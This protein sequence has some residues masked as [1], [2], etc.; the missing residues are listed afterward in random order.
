MRSLW[1]DP[2]KTGQE[3]SPSGLC[4][5]DFC[6]LHAVPL[7]LATRTP[8]TPHPHPAGRPSDSRES[9][10]HQLCLRQEGGLPPGG[11]SLWIT[12]TWNNDLRATGVRATLCMLHPR[13]WP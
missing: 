9:H 6:S 4:F 3:P 5:W 8:S 11:V 2:C 1:D 13:P 10:E 12:G 7:Q